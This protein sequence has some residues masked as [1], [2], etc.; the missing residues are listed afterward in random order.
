MR[1][2]DV[3]LLLVPRAG[4]RGLSV[5]S[6]KVYEYLAAERPILALVPPEGDAATLLRDTGS[7]W[8][9]DP[10]DEAAIAAAIAEAAGAWEADRLGE[11]R[12]T[13]EWRERLDR[14]T[15]AREL[16]ELLR[17]VAPGGSRA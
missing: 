12:L 2:A 15:R 13:T 3:L 10:D 7:A 6:G 9:A 14:R 16:A 11:R 5:V 17:D 1:A 4:G 8:I